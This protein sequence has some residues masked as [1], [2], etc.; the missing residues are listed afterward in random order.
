MLQA[1]QA[2]AARHRVVC[3][4]LIAGSYGAPVV[5]VEESAQPLAALDRRDRERQLS[6][7]AQER[8]H[9]CPPD[10]ALGLSVR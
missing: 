1:T 7:L 4:K 10:R 9:G 2:G 6:P 3:Q 8:L 5:E